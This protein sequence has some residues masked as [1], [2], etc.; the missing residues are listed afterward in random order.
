MRLSKKFLAAGAAVLLSVGAISA[1]AYS[2]STAKPYWACLKSGILSNVGTTKPRCS[3]P[4]VAIQLSTPGAQGLKGA[5]GAQGIQGIQGIQGV[6]GER[7]EA[8]P[9]LVIRPNENPLEPHIGDLEVVDYSLKLVRDSAGTFWII[10]DQEENGFELPR[11]PWGQI[12]TTVFFL[13]DD[14]TGQPMIRNGYVK[15]SGG[16]LGEKNIYIHDPWLGATPVFELLRGSPL[17]GLW[18]VN[19]D[20]L[21]PGID[22][23]VHSKRELTGLA[24][25][26][27]SERFSCLKTKTSIKPVVLV[28]PASYPNISMDGWS[29]VTR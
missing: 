28:R 23:E 11:S 4:A 9:G 18:Q 24:D 17:D 1:N 27:P 29:F 19:T 26:D 3:K 7:G 25:G 16:I 2:A 21:N 13:T 6:P 20:I 14:C 15:A 22:I 8:G 5:K 10:D 12:E